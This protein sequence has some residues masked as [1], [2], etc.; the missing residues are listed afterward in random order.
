[1]S[2]D[3]SLIQVQPTEVFSRNI[4]HN[5][6]KMAKAAGIYMHLWRPDELGLAKAHELIQPLEAGLAE[7]VNNP[8]KYKAYDAP[9]GW[10]TYEHF[11]PFVR[12]VLEA[13]KEYPDAT[14]EVSR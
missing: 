13:C 3:I 2:L 12:E 9:N 11:I 6:G 5:L 7:L 14:I 10:G 4:T 1:M 8:E